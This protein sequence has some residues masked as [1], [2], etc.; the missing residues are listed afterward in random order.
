MLQMPLRGRGSFERVMNEDKIAFWA[1]RRVMNVTR[2]KTDDSF[3]GTRDQYFWR[4]EGKWR[5]NNK[6]KEHVE[7]AIVL[8]R[9]L[10]SCEFV[11]EQIHH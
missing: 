9:S 1:R 10:Y 2:L 5:E 7:C 8:Q 3:L 4:E 11:A 6:P